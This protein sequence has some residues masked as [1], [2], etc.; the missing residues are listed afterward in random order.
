MR[1][2]LAIILTTALLLSACGS[3]KKDFKV[4]VMSDPL[5]AYALMQVTY[6]DESNSDWIFLGPTPIDIQK[7]V[8]F[9]NAESVSLKVI[10]P[11]FYEQVKTWK[12]KDF[13]KEHK[14]GKGIR[15]VPNM[16]Q[17]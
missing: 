13:V 12:A 2:K 16:V 4:N 8:S 14:S 1:L 7:K 6:K 17:Q 11:G 5:G 15:W 9:A 10:R 3:G